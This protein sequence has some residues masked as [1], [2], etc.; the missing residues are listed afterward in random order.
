MPLSEAIRHIAHSVKQGKT[1]L[2]IQ[3]EP[4]HLGRIHVSLATDASRQVQIHLITDQAVTRHAI[5]QQLPALRQAL[6]DHGLDLSSFS[7]GG[8]STQDGGGSTGGSMPESRH[9]SE[10]AFPMAAEAAPDPQSAPPGRENR[11]PPGRLS[12]HA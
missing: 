8:Q 9:R 12:I 5:E 7:T 10:P 11:A 3:L 2:D 4:A 6:A 1:R